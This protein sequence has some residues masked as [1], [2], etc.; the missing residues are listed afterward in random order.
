MASIRT[1]TR[2]FAGGEIAPELYGRVDLAKFQTGLAE[3]KNFIVLPHGPIANRPGTEYI[4]ATKNQ[5]NTTRLIPFSYSTTQTYALEFGDQYIRFFTQGARLLAGTVTGWLTATVYA[6]GDIRSQAGVNYYCRTAHTSNVFA[7]DLAASKWYALTSDIVEV[8]TLYL[9]A[10]IAAIHYVQSADVLTLVHP[11]YAPRELRRLGAAKWA[12]TE[13]SFAPGIAA[14]TGV[15]VTATAGAGAITYSYVVTA[16]ATEDQDESLVSAIVSC[17]NALSTAG[18]HNTVTWSAVTGA[19]RYNVYKAKSGLYGYI[20]Q[21]DALSFQDDNI[22]SDMSITPGIPQTLF[23]STNNYPGAVSYFEQRRC[24]AGS[25]NSPQTIWTTR[26]ATEKN[27]NYSIPSKDNDALTLKILAREANTIRHLVPLSD[28]MALTSGGEFKLSSGSADALTPTTAQIKAQSY[29]GASNVQP[30]VTGNSILYAQ[31]RGAR[32]REITYS[33][34]AQSYKTI[35]ASIMAPHL[36]DGYTLT[37][38]AYMRA[39]YQVLWVVRSDGLLLGLTYVPD[40]Q[41]IAWHQHP[42][43]GATIDSI[44]VI[45]EGSEDVLYMAV[46]RTINGSPVCY[47]ERM[48]TR[49]FTNPEDVFFI[50]CGLTYDSTPATTISGLSH[51]EGKDVA[52][53]ADGAVVG[54]LTVTSGAITLPAAASV[55]QIGLPITASATTLPIAFETAGMGQG[56]SKNV[57]TAFL[58]VYRSSGIFVGPSTDKLREYRQRTNEVYGSPPSLQSDEIEIVLS[59]EWT[60]GGQLVIEHTDPLPLTISSM[61]L[62]VT[63]GG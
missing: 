18:N 40:Q 63:V 15:A 48:S 31:D 47:V 9:A 57:A 58:R 53:L 23:A 16:V 38:M 44:C 51:L 32:I 6:V 25:N 19:V 41:V 62:E 52:V 24:F 12:L 37:D 26:S 1:L 61:S 60:K 4:A 7:T 50:D 13:I 17:T 29:M 22:A 33:W 28:L 10:D 30:S 36:F 54:G 21:T 42:M 11:S 45:A 55:V 3:C 35:D 46:N 5:A 59:P 39:P 27:L 34:E 8:P 2:S 56:R 20:G 49:L 14:P 43:D